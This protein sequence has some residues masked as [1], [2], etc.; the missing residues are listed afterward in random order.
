MCLVA[1]AFANPAGTV[2]TYAA[3]PLPYA[4]SGYPY[5]GYAYAAK[6]VAYT[7][8]SSPLTYTTQYKPQ[9]EYSALAYN[10]AYAYGS[11]YLY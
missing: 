10:P 6:P 11:P 8:Y 4:Y 1:A 7:Q 2:T 5:P 3:A 9:V